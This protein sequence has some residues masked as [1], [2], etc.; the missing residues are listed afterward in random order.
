M[1][2][3]A[4]HAALERQYRTFNRR[5]FVHPD[6]L[7]FLYA[8][9]DPADQ[10]VVALVASSLAYGHVK[11]ILRSV[12]R[13]L[14]RMGPAPARFVRE[15]SAARMARAMAGFKHRFTTDA[16]LTAM[17]VGARRAIRRHGSLG[18]CFRSVLGG[19]DETVVSALEAFVAEL[20]GRGA[21]N[22]LLPDPARRS[23]CKR[24]HLMLRWMVRRD[25]VDPGPWRGVPARLLVVPL[26]THMLRIARATG[27]TQ[28]AA[29]DLATA[30]EVT[31][32]FRAVRP[33][34]PVR[35]DFCLTRLGIHPEGRS[36]DF[37]AQIAT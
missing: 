27:L 2:A 23:A 14:E 15:T 4:Y 3:R 37:L 24:L 9:D 5:R 28:R 36:C 13:V 30:L 35:Y 6:P 7:E 29:G 32:A 19:G 34:D 26:D 8:Y 11:Q 25:E 12:S 17:F 18:A 16:E 10:E 33:D 21:V 1:P 22:S 20:G 31:A